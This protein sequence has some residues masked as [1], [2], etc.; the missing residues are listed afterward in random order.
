MDE[1]TKRIA[2]I[3]LSALAIGIITFDIINAASVGTASAD[4]TRFFDIIKIA[5]AMLGVLAGAFA[6]AMSYNKHR[7]DEA[8]L[9]LDVTNH[10][11][12]VISK[13]SERF[14]KA[15]ELLGNEESIA[16]RIGG[17][18]AFEK[19]AEDCEADRTRIS[20]VLCT[21]M[22]EKRPVADI[23]NTEARKPPMDLATLLKVVVKMSIQY[24]DLEL[25]LDFSETDLRKTYLR[26]A[27]LHNANL[28]R[29]NLFRADLRDTNL[30]NANLY[31]A[32]L[33]SADLRNADLRSANLSDADLSGADLSGANLSGANLSG[34][35][36]GGANLSGAYII[37]ANL[38][39][40]RLSGANL[41]G[42]DLSFSD[43]S[44]LELS[45]VDLTNA[46]YDDNQLAKAR[47]YV[48]TILTDGTHYT[49]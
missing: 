4:I 10:E 37:R 31:S 21:Y 49:S 15:M 29:A 36:L 39:S 43:L 45:F 33:I 11:L 2:A 30:S 12:D 5:I 40:A 1:S 14:T 7:L 44:G 34:A 13:T 46:E 18:Y 20:D 19:L 17:I 35:R 24:K 6:A 22:R 32:K 8:S 42:A 25:K 38:G 47:L 3:I 27:N 23:G 48:N 41:K 26:S 16:I 28:F 9:K